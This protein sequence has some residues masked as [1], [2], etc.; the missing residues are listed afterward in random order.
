MLETINIE[1]VCKTHKEIIIII[2]F[3]VSFLIFYYLGYKNDQKSIV[4]RIKIKQAEQYLN[5][6]KGENEDFF[7][8][9]TYDLS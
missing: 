3:W 6:Y 5:K 2:V 7:I 9:P 1:H 8:G 4:K